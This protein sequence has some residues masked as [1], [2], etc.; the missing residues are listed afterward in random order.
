MSL[1]VSSDLLAAAER[2]NV[3]DTDLLHCV[4][5]SLPY[6]W[7]V[8]STV[9]STSTPEVTISQT[10]KFPHRRKWSAASCCGPW[11]VTRSVEASSVTSA[12]NWRSKAATESPRSATTLSRVSATSSS[13]RRGDSCSTNLRSY[14]TVDRHT[15]CDSGPPVSTALSCTLVALGPL[16]GKVD[17]G[18]RRGTDR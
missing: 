1:D 3:S 16:V 4:R 10:T 15:E 14:A 6:A 5:T 11:P 8:V 17:C 7:E 9:M 13:C 2:G 18:R 12:P